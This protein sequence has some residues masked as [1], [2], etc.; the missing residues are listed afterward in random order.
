M[1]HEGLCGCN[2]YKPAAS[3]SSYNYARDD[4]KLN[5][6]YAATARTDAGE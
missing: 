4:S 6:S 5:Y 1:I 3:G 2:I